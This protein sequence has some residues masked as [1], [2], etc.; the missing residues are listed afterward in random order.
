AEPEWVASSTGEETLIYVFNQQLVNFLRG[1]R[2]VY[3][4]KVSFVPDWPYYDSYSDLAIFIEAVRPQGRLRVFYPGFIE[5][6]DI[7]ATDKPGSCELNIGLSAI[8]DSNG[9]IDRFEVGDNSVSI[10]RRSSDHEIWERLAAR[11]GECSREETDRDRTDVV[12]ASVTIEQGATKI[13]GTLA[14]NCDRKASY[15]AVF[16]GGSGLYNRDGVGADIRVGY[17]TWCR[18]MASRGID[19]IRYDRYDFRAGTLLEQLNTATFT[20]LVSQAARVYEFVVELSEQRCQLPVL[21]GHSLGGLIVLALA[22][23]RLLE[24]AVLISTPSRNMREIIR[25]QA[26][27]LASKYSGKRPDLAEVILSKNARFID[28]IDGRRDVETIEN[29]L[30]RAQVRARARMFRSLFDVAGARLAHSAKCERAVVIQ[31]CEDEQVLQSNSQE[32]VAALNCDNIIHIL[33]AGRNHLLQMP[34]GTDRGASEWTRCS[35]ERDAAE[36]LAT[37]I[38]EALS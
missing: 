34:A 33:A 10:N 7:V 1:D 29:P 28:I 12:E 14:S 36:F 11:R 23:T 20:S 27:Q 15:L 21:I 2:A 5:P 18:E 3:V 4:E 30:A 16:V 13:E 25:A 17:A 24:R 26:Q 38:V 35:L 32:L 37:S 8:F 19:N 6:V 22:Q 9:R 31:G